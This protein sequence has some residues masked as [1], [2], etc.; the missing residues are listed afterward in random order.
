MLIFVFLGLIGVY[1]LA[2]LIFSMLYAKCHIIWEV[3]AGFLSFVFYLP[4]FS[5]IFYL[6]G[7]CKFDK[8]DLLNYRQITSKNWNLIRE[9]WKSQRILIM[10]KYL[11]W[12]IIFGTGLY[13]ATY[14]PLPAYYCLFIIVCLYSLPAVIKILFAFPY[15]LKQRVKS[16]CGKAP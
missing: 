3:F 6:Q 9:S 11:F 8:P 2:L 14:F 16:C 4:T 5:G 15:L 12:N 13:I 7:I 1:I 10:S